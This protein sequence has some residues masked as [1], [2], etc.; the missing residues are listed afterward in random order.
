M[1]KWIRERWVVC[2]ASVANVQPA[3]IR[4]AAFQRTS[5]LNV[6][7]HCPKSCSEDPEHETTDND[8]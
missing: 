7:R 1:R 2:G 5:V 4:G 8:R 6:E 3:G